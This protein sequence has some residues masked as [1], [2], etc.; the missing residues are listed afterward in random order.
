MRSRILRALT[1]LDIA[2]A[3]DIA[4]RVNNSVCDT[5]HQ[6]ESLVSIGHADKRG[7]CY[8]F[9]PAGFRAVVEAA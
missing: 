7:G 9:T 4:A 8:W 1:R 3:E 2:T 5:R 6:L